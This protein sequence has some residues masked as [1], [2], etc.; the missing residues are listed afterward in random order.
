MLEYFNN[1]EDK[2]LRISSFNSSKNILKMINSA[3]ESRSPEKFHHLVRN[4]RLY[5]SSPA[6]EPLKHYISCTH[7]RLITC[8]AVLHSF[9]IE[10]NFKSLKSLFSTVKDP[11]FRSTYQ[12]ST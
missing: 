12:W 2:F 11:S 10:D 4:L 1:V 6:Q 5:N 9:K 7:H 8:Q 3:N